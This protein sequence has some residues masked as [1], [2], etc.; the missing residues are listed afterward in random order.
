MDMYDDERERKIAMIEQFY[1][2]IS[3]TE[4]EKLYELCTDDVRMS[5]PYQLPGFPNHGEGKDN[6]RQLNG[7]M[8][9]YSSTAQTV[10]KVEPMLNPDSFLVEVKG[11]M[12]V[13]ETG[14]PYRNDYLNIFRFRDGKIA[15]WVSYHD[16][17]RQLVAFGFTELP[18][19]A[20]S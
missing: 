3:A 11:D 20:E 5:I 14:R 10:S 7:A 6:L 4:Y 15:E 2:F 13:R 8:D 18:I 12:V 16:P 19:P 9:K 1:E 17:V